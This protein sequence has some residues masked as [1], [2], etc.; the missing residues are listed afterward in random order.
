MQYI[1][2]P[3]QLPLDYVVP[4]VYII[5]KW[6]GIITVTTL[7]KEMGIKNIYNNRKWLNDSIQEMIDQ[8]WINAKKIKNSKYELGEPNVYEPGSFRSYKF[9]DIDL[10]MHIKEC[11]PIMLVKYYIVLVGSINYKTHI[12]FCSLD[13]LSERAGINLLTAIKYNKILAKNGIIYYER[14]KNMGVCNRYGLY[15]DREFVRQEAI[16]IS[17]Q[18]GKLIH[19]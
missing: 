7:L 9:N 18:C 2:I 1:Y 14:F 8:G 10:L 5:N 19:S 11:N 13:T 12:G 16:R 3:N 4:F 17:L 15:D 6:S